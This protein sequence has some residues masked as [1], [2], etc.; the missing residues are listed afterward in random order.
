MYA[1]FYG[2]SKKPF[3]LTPDP[4]FFFNSTVHKRGLAYLHYGLEQGEGF[5]VVTGSPG[6]GKTMLVK[7]LLE[8]ILYEAIIPGLMVT[9]QVGAEDTLRMVAGAFGLAYDTNTKAMLLKSIEYFFKLKAKEGKRLLLVVDEAQNLPRQSLEELRMLLNFEFGGKP[10][11]QIFMLGQEE[12]RAH[13]QADHMEQIRQRITATYHLRPL[14][15][16]ETCEYIVHRLLKAGWKSDPVLTD[17]TFDQ[18]YRFSGGTPRL[19]NSLCDRLLLYGFLE[20]LHVLDGDAC[21]TVIDEI[22]QDS[23]YLKPE[24][25]LS[26]A[27]PHLRDELDLPPDSFEGRLAQ[28]ENSVTELRRDLQ[29]ERALLRKAILIQLDLNDAYDMS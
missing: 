26:P 18:I 19:I 11:M 8:T 27:A 15:K 13:L 2:L 12:L 10:I 14:E 7:E 17:D 4:E 24:S 6:T 28:L 23:N 22:E 20:E 9:S 25:P 29:K 5:I 1:D 16:E 21:K 3:Q